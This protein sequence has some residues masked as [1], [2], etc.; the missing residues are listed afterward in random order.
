MLLFFVLFF[1]KSK[2]YRFSALKRP[3]IGV[4]KNR[5]VAEFIQGLLFENTYLTVLKDE[6]S[7]KLKLNA[8]T[9]NFDLIVRSKNW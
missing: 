5:R 2:S 1:Y 3:S 6:T 8:S 7:L 4:Y 9:F